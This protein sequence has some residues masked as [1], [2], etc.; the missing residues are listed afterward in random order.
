M[1]FV[2]QTDDGTTQG[3]NAYVELSYFKAYHDAAGNDY[4]GYT[5]DELQNVIVRGTRYVDTRF[6]YKGVKLLGATTAAT[7]T[8]TATGNFSDNETVTIGSR[9]YKFQATLTNVNGNVQIGADLATSLVNIANAINGAGTPGT[10]YAAAMTQNTNIIATQTDT[11]LTVTASNKGFSGNAFAS[12]T[13]ASLATWSG[14]TLSGGLG[15]QST[16]WPRAAGS[17]TV[18]PWFDVNFLTAPVQ[19]GAYGPV[20]L[21]D[22]SG[23]ALI[24]I[25]DAVKDACSEY[26]L[27]ATTIPLWQDAPAPAG[28]RLIQSISQMVDVIKQDVTYEPGQVGS[29][30]MPAFPAADM[31]LARAGIIEVGRTLY[32]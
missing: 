20:T 2:V 29:F 5:D 8:L 13:T 27:R 16:Q 3:A 7:G 19:V 22:S 6:P 9:S 28:G 12:T 15:P 26:A 24:G 32:R 1:A 17:S 25:P 21:I 23:N 4:S 30:A 18:F 11:T 31:I 14:A 10:D